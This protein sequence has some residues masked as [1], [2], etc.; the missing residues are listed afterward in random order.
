MSPLG[1][2]EQ[3]IVFSPVEVRNPA[4]PSSSTSKAKPPG[5]SKKGKKKAK[6][7]VGA[8]GIEDVA[9][10]L[11]AGSLNPTVGPGPITRSMMGG[12][13]EDRVGQDG[14]DD[15]DMYVTEEESA[16]DEGGGDGTIEEKADGEGDIQVGTSADPPPRKKRKSTQKDK[17]KTPAKSTRGSTAKTTPT[18]AAEPNATQG[19]HQQ[20]TPPTGSGISMAIDPALETLQVPRNQPSPQASGSGGGI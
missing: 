9:G 8:S 17:G 14:D 16:I 7:N 20:G 18:T 12:K 2:T 4:S 19:Q 3:R 10:S 15:D 6:A 11:N 13:E 5:N 1:T